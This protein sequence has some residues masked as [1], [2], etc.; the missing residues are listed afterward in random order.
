[1]YNGAAQYRDGGGR[2]KTRCREVVKRS[3]REW[4]RGGGKTFMQRWEG[5]VAEVGRECC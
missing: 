3:Q 4:G 2:G 1:M 5:N